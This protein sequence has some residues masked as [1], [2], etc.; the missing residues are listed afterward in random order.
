MATM[1]QGSLEGCADK[2]SKSSIHRGELAYLKQLD[3]PRMN[4][5]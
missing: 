2:S 5:Q 4:K 3:F 1:V